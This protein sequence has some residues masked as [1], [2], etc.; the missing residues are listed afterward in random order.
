MTNIATKSRRTVMIFRSPYSD[1]QIPATPLTPFALRH[2]G[3]LADKAA[4]IDGLTGQRLTYGQLADGVRTM[5]AAL[6]DRGFRKGDVFAIY[7]PNMPEYAIAFHAVVSLGGIVTMVNP[8]ATGEE[9]VRQLI[10]AGATYLLTV[11]ECLERATEAAD[12]SRVRELF[13]LGDAPGH[14]PFSALLGGSGTPPTVPIRPHE[15]LAALPYSSGTTGFPKGVMLTHANL[16]ADAAQIAGCGVVS[17]QDTLIGILPFFHIY[18]LAVLNHFGL[19]TGA[20][21]VTLPRFELALFLQTLETYDV[22]V[23]HL[24]PPVVLALAKQSVVKRYDLS[25]LKVVISGGAPL[26][27]DVANACREQIGCHVEQAYGL[28]EAS[29]VTHLGPADPKRIKVE[30]IGLLLP[31]TEA[32]FVDPTSGAELEAEQPGEL[33]IRGPQ[34]MKGYLN[35]PEATAQMITADGWLRT[36]D[37]GYADAEGHFTILDRLKELIKYKAYQVAPAELEAVLLAHPAVADVA[38]IPS[39][40]EDA[41][42]VPK[43]FVVLRDEA[44]A[45]ELMAYVAAQVTPYKKVRRIEFIDQIPKSASGKILRRVLVERERAATRVPVIA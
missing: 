26:G 45:D 36:G 7:T 32:K 16:V 41:G 27:A 40:D 19:A 17:E 43:A 15:D 38:V 6:A 5:A 2:A 42:E 18:G 23:A 35:R 28:T 11:P 13:V 29:P 9:L 37:L 25:R 30:S 1:V 10:D 14:T 34:V 24:V 12:R 8:A 4:I 22:S 31:N 39:P 3:R 33:W 21:I 20:T 44:T